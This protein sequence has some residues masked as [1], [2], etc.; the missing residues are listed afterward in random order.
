MAIIY[1]TKNYVHSTSNSAWTVLD[2]TYLDASS[3]W[4]TFTEFENTM[5]DIGKVHEMCREYPALNKAYENFKI[6]YT[7]HGYRHNEKIKSEFSIII[8]I[9]SIFSLI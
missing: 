1:P 5:P 2:E 7:I 3:Q 9:N 8:S 4:I 6:I